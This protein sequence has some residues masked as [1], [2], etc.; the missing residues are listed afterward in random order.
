[1]AAIGEFKVRLRQALDEVPESTP[2]HAVQELMRQRAG[3][4]S[5][6]EEASARL[7]AEVIEPRMRVLAELLAASRLV[8]RS[9]QRRCAIFLGYQERFPAHAR[10]EFS[11]AAA[12]GL[13]KLRLDRE[14]YIAPA[15]LAFDRFA[16]WECQLDA[17]DVPRV[18]TWVESEIIAFVAC[19]SRFVQESARGEPVPAMDPVCGMRIAIDSASPHGDYLGHC[20]Y[21]C[22]TACRD[23]FLAEPLAYVTITHD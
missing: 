20:Y 1:M 2:T 16:L 6:F 23:K 3:R 7:L 11:I 8:C 9:S 10:F 22:S 13:S 15:F 4:E 14:T 17:L 18:E 12:A 21:F 19:L 5:Q